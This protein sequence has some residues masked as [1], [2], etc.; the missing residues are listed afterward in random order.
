VETGPG[1]EAIQ[2]GRGGGQQAVKG[3]STRCRPCDGWASEMRGA[4]G[5]WP[6]PYS[7][8]R[9]ASN[10]ERLAHGVAG[11]KGCR[12]RPQDNLSGAGGGQEGG[13]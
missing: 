6:K 12:F 9:K 2:G 3:Q 4:V 8:R 13:A 7:D 10:L 11:L 1:T 5:T